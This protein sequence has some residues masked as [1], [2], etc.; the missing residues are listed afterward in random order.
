MYIWFNIYICVKCT[1]KD[2]V[3]HHKLVYTFRLIETMDSPANIINFDIHTVP[4]HGEL[5]SLYEISTDYKAKIATETSALRAEEKELK[6]M[7]RRL[8]EIKKD[9]KEKETHINTEVIER[10]K[11]VLFPEKSPGDKVTFTEFIKKS[12]AIFKEQGH[13]SSTTSVEIS[14]MLYIFE[15]EYGFE[16]RHEFKTGQDAV[17]WTDLV[18]NPVALI[19]NH[20]IAQDLVSDVMSDSIDEDKITA[21]KKLGKHMY[22]YLSSM[23]FET[24]QDNKY[25]AFKSFLDGVL[26]ASY[27]CHS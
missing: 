17:S 1:Y 7:E 3:C 13:V 14:R 20:R 8:S 5:F 10:I 27:M 9:I 21:L 6:L 15:S 25:V 18:D 2:Y 26:E 12:V 4:S 23:D 24:K 22:E 11:H 19:C 16:D